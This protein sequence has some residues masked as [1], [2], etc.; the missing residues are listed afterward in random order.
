MSFMG[1]VA[2]KFLSILILFVAFPAWSSVYFVGQGGLLRL[3]Q[4]AA[5]ENNVVPQG[6]SYGGGIG[7]RQNFF[8][9]EA[10]VLK[11]TAEA[12]VKH[13]GQ[14]NTMVH[15][16]SSILL[17]LNF[18]LKKEI[19]LRVGYGFHRIDQ[20]LGKETSDASAA[21]AK[22]AYDFQEKA[23][24]EGVFFGGGYVIFDTKSL[25][26]FVQLERFD[27]STYDAG[28]WNVSLG[29]KFRL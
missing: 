17:A 13:D 3:Y 1:K 4:K 5:E 16:Q 2:A 27:F 18:Y 29:I 14:S 6:F 12:D 21:G 8:E 11:S 7:F 22:E 9:Y 20:R 15:N 24:S 26:C 28:A 19:Y 10:V 23:V 25:D